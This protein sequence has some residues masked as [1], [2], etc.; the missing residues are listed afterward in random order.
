MNVPCSTA[1]AGSLRTAARICQTQHLAL[2]S[3]QR[4]QHHRQTQM[5]R[6]HSQRSRTQHGVRCRPCTGTVSMAAQHG[7]HLQLPPCRLVITALCIVHAARLC[8]TGSVAEMPPRLHSCQP[9]C[10]PQFV[11]LPSCCTACMVL[12]RLFPPLFVALP[13]MCPCANA[14]LSVRAAG[15]FTRQ[16]CWQ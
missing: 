6:A 9:V 12:T 3:G 13:S 4:S 8:S 7:G 10:L 1:A 11:C 5:R 14:L 16:A 2:L 15:V